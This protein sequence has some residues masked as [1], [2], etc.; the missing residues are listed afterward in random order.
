MVTSAEKRKLEVRREARVCGVAG[1]E[2]DRLSP[3]WGDSRNLRGSVARRAL[4][5]QPRFSR[6]F[7]TCWV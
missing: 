1:L 3:D 6:S 2:A 7:N 4:C 5:P